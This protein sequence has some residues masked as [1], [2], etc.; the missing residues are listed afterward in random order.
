MKAG[1]AHQRRHYWATAIFPEL[2]IFGELLFGDI[3]G[4]ISRLNRADR[5]KA[6]PMLDLIGAAIA[7]TY[8]IPQTGAE[9]RTYFRDRCLQPLC[10]LL[11]PHGDDGVDNSRSARGNP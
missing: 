10:H 2:W 4:D 3:R 6:A 11:R 9:G 7:T 8:R 1:R 5:C